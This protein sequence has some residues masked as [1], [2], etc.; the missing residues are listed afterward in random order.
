MVIIGTTMGREDVVGG[1]EVEGEGAM[2]GGRETIE[3]ALVIGSC[4]R[5]LRLYDQRRI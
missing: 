2:E 3:Y 1:E 5:H 4:M